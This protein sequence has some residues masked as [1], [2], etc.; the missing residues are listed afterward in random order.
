M[1]CQSS[2]RNLIVLK[3]LC[4]RI[5]PL[6]DTLFMYISFMSHLIV[7]GQTN[8]K[9]FINHEMKK[10]NKTDKVIYVT[11]YIILAPFS[12]LQQRII[13]WLINPKRL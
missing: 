5:C 9:S 10:T 3:W 12:D 4:A 8:V 7:S 11:L 6:P 2:E 1:S 13:A